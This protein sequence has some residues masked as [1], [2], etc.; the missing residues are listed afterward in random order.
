MAD[1]AR[2]LKFA[3]ILVACGVS[4]VFSGVLTWFGTQSAL[5][6]AV[7]VNT[8]EMLAVRQDIQELKH[9]IDKTAG[10]EITD[11]KIKNLQ[12]QIDQQEEHL[13]ANDRRL[14]GRR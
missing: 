7:T 5:S 14:D 13:R 12:M 9:S 6:T 4:A 2:G 10:A 8:Q 11:Q 1:E 3:P